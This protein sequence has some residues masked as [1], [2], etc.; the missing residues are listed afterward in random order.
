MKVATSTLVDALN[1]AIDSAE[2]ELTPMQAAD[3]FSLREIRTSKNASYDRARKIL[4]QMIASGLAVEVG[5]RRR[6]SGGR[7]AMAYKLVVK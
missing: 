3:E 6:S 4:T 1:A 5:I 2:A 7:E